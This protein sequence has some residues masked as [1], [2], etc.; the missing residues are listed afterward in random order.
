MMPDWQPIETAPTDGTW[1]WVYAPGRDGLCPIV[2]L[3]HYH[4]GAGWCVDELREVTMWQP[5]DPAAFLKSPPPPKKDA[6][7]DER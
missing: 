5:A 2:C 1:V 4:D 7:Y 6:D 3:A